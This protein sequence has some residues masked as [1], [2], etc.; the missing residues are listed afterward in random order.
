MESLSQLGAQ[1][2]PVWSGQIETSRGQMETAIAGLSMR[3]AGIVDRLNRA[4]EMS[5]MSGDA[6]AGLMGVFASSQQELDR[7]VVTLKSAMDSKSAMLARIKQL[8]QFTDELDAMAADVARIAQQTNLLALNAAI[9]AARAGEHGRSF[10]VVA[11]E[12][13][14]LS[15]LSGDTGKSMAVK[16]GVIGETIRSV[17]TSVEQSLAGETQS[18]Q[19]CEATITAVLDKFREATDALLEASNV[20]REHRSYL[21][22][23]IGEALVHLQFQDRISQIMSHVRGNIDRMPV[24]LS[25]QRE[26]FERDQNLT[27]IDAA[28][29]LAELESTYAMAEERAIHAGT[30]QARLPNEAGGGI[31]KPQA[32]TDITFF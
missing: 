9:E 11:Q 27:P 12:V 3:F 2:M 26:I 15:K 28:G 20:N 31:P 22:G 14:T 32:S 30:S 21:Q 8:E 16:V 13:R 17:C 7:V 19:D 23:E 1:V 18:T 10:S 5:E 29:L 24:L 6:N 4:T 25:T